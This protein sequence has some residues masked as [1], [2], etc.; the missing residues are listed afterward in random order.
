VR[1]LESLAEDSATLDAYLQEIARFPPITMAEERALA[2][3]VQQRDQDALAGLVGSHLNMVV[4]YA[5]RYR[6]LGVSLLALV[7]DGNLA[8]LDAARRFDPDQHGPF[9]TYALWWVRQGLLHRVS[10]VDASE[11]GAS[12]LDTG[13][14]RFAAAL[15]AA[16]E[17]AYAPADGAGDEL[18]AHDIRMLDEH[19]LRMPEPTR[20]GDDDDLDLEDLGPAIV[21]EPEDP[22]R[23]ALVS[24]LEA[25]LLELEPKERRVLELQLGLRDGEPRSLDQ[26]GT[27]L[28]VSLARVERLSARAVRKLR[29]QRSVRSSLN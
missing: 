9:A 6:H 4:R 14:G 26:V 13:A 15:E 5:C 1:R 8:L 25:S 27:R 10:L 18:T 16:V 28:R 20:L 29:R 24:Q 19:W 17:H 12:D 2:A 22:V 23:L 3:R 11:A 7:H 21:A